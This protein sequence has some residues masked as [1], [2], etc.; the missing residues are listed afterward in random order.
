[1]AG[2]SQIKNPIDKVADQVRRQIA[3]PFSPD[4]TSAANFNGNAIAR[5]GAVMGGSLAGAVPI[6]VTKEGT[7]AGGNPITI[8]AMFWG[9]DNWGGNAQWG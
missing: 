3:P 1:M 4:F 9:L 8:Y 2:R 6:D 5:S 7:D